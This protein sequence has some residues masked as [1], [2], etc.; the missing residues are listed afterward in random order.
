MNDE[1]ILIVRG[2]KDFDDLKRFG[3]PM[4]TKVSKADIVIAIDGDRSIVLKSRER[5]QADFVDS[6]SQISEL[7]EIMKHLRSAYVAARPSKDAHLGHAI[8]GLWF[9]Y[10]MGGT[11]VIQPTPDALAAAGDMRGLRE[12][13][14]TFIESDFGL[15]VGS[16]GKIPA[17]GGSDSE[18]ARVSRPVGQRPEAPGDSR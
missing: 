1:T 12:S 2:V 4:A 10:W 7:A 18:T 3:L 14:T 5:M 6:E 13:A 17:D 16:A 15:R 8:V 9:F 11:E